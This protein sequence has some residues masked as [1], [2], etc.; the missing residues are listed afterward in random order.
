[1]SDNKQVPNME[2]RS[3]AARNEFN[4]VAAQVSEAQVHQ[5]T[6][7]QSNGS[8]HVQNQHP[9]P[10]YNMQGEIAEEAN[11]QRHQ[12]EM[13]T[14][15]QAAQQRNERSRELIEAAKL[16][17]TFNNAAQGNRNQNDQGFRR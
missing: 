15:D 2:L 4:S 3:E 9:S 6:E 17:Q 11:R 8:A 5:Q 16:Q 13:S 14:D 1:M 7:Q 12:A 10:Q